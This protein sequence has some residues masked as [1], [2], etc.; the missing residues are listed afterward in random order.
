MT[1]AAKAANTMLITTARS[2]RIAAATAA[3]PTARRGAGAGANAANRPPPG[4]TGAAN[5]CRFGDKA[6]DI[7]AAMRTQH[8]MKAAMTVTAPIAM[9]TSMSASPP[10]RAAVV[11]AMTHSTTAAAGAQTSARQR[12]F[13]FRTSMTRGFGMVTPGWSEGSRLRVPPTHAADRTGEP[14]TNV[15]HRPSPRRLVVRCAGRPA[16]RCVIPSQPGRIVHRD[17]AARGR[18]S[19]R[20]PGRADFAELPNDRPQ[21]R[22]RNGR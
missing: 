18:R 10:T 3:G 13:G 20:E 9:V 5:R 1:V 6:R 8:A 14:T 19:S 12:S 2:T 7:P 22:S 4:V 16:G 11:D 17:I 15:H 21:L